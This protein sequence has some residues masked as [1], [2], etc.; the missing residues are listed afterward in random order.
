L[1]GFA[2]TR[3]DTLRVIVGFPPGGTTDAFARRVGEKLRGTYANTVVVDNK[4]GAGGQ[5][6]VMTLKNS[7]PDGAH[8]LY[9]PASMLTI[10]PH[11]YSKLGYAQSDVAPIGMGHSTDHALVVGPAVPD[12]VKTVKDFVEWAKANPGKASIGN[13]GAGSMPHLLAGRLAMITGAQIT[14]VP[15][16]GSGPA[17]PQVLGGQLAGM[18]SPLGDWVQHYKGGKVRALATSGPERSPYTPD[19]A[20]YREQGFSELVVREWFGFFAPAA[21]PDAVKEVLNA[22]L[23]AA[24]AQQ[25]VREFITPLGGHIEASTTAEHA[26]RLAADSNLAKGLVTALNFKADS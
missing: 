11:S 6:G 1:P 19:V 25:D 18:S 4:P 9:S 5:L 20:T 7:A 17:I 10:Y 15:F 24:R 16:A 21:T 8:I 26:R 23:R 22:A 3:V 12:S 14:N 13:P 2:Q